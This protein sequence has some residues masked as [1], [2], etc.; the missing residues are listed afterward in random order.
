MSRERDVTDIYHKC[1]FTD[2][3]LTH[4]HTKLEKVVTVC[5]LVLSKMVVISNYLP[6]SH[7]ITVLC[8]CVCVCVCVFVLLHAYGQ[9]GVCPGLQFNM[10]LI[11][12]IAVIC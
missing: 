6:A 11:T 12:F 10:H 2:F 8:V 1:Y 9:E 5:R 7:K 3:L 4:W